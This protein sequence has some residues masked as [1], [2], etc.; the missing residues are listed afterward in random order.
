MTYELIID[1]ETALDALPEAQEEKQ[2]EKEHEEQ[3]KKYTAKMIAYAKAWNDARDR[4]AIDPDRYP[5]PEGEDIPLP[6][7]IP[8]VE[9]WS[10]EKIR[11][12]SE[13]IINNPDRLDR[14]KAFAQFVNAESHGLI[15]FA[16]RPGFCLQQAYN[17][18][19]SGPV[20]GMA[21]S[22]INYEANNTMLLN[23]PLQRPEYNPH[24]AILRTLEGHTSYVKAVSI[25]PD[26]KRAVSVSWD[27]TLRVWDLASGQCLKTL[28]GHTSSFKSV[29]ITQDG[30]RAVL[31]SYDSTI[32]LWDL[33]SGQC[34]KTL[35]GHT[36][37]VNSVSITPDGKLAVSGS[38]D[39]TLRVWDLD[40]GLCVKTLEGHTNGVYVVC[41]T[42]DGKLAVSGSLDKTLRVWDLE[43]GQCLKTLDGHTGS[44]LS[45]SIT[46]DGKRTVSGS[47]DNTLRLWDL[48]S[49]Q[50]LKT[51]EGHP[52]Y[53]DFIFT[54]RGVESVS[55]TCDGKRAV[56]ASRDETLRVWDL[57]GGQC[58][59]QYQAKNVVVSISKIRANGQFAYGTIL[60]DV[61]FLTIRDLPMEPP[62]VTPVGIWLFG[63]NGKIGQ[64]DKAIKTL[65]PWC[66]EQSP[67]ADK[68]LDVIK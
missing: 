24:P 63:E 4:H 28:E 64:W 58:V 8:S 47:S 20:T 21:E 57:E 65:C 51:L 40:S 15:K 33:A 17:F 14:M 53:K 46:P 19:D 61:I 60:G 13:R 26:G 42:S 3:L 50:C 16:S 66:G 68:V 11:E 10:D 56:S 55:V 6:E 32:R 18:A 2:K 23:H 29:N 48:A 44:V 41:I 67:V 49:G 25:T 7:S 36:L 35:K 62:I 5:M 27:K 45:I 22:I 30:K 31:G 59:A 39:T 38:D 12:D 54:K 37:L 52:N 1:Y 9:P 43:N 34:L